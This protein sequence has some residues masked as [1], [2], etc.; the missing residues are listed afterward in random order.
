MMPAPIFIY[1]PRAFSTYFLLRLCIDE[2]LVCVDDAADG[3]PVVPRLGSE[4]MSIAYDTVVGAR[5]DRKKLLRAHV[6][7]YGTYRHR[8]DPGLARRA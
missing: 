2:K 4:Y 7:L 6:M 8:T 1:R 3:G 5:L